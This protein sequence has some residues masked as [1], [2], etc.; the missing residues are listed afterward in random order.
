MLSSFEHFRTIFIC[1]MSN[2]R[3]VSQRL[4]VNTS[5]GPCAQG[6]SGASKTKENKERESGNMK[7]NGEIW[8]QTESQR[9]DHIKTGIPRHMKQT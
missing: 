9:G 7:S 1:F 6:L 8:K 3:M 4:S 2:L 5:A